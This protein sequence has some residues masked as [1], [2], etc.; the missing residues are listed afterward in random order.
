MGVWESGYGDPKTMGSGVP[1]EG[2][3]LWGQC[4]GV[5]REGWGGL[6]PK[7]MLPSS[8]RRRRNSPSSTSAIQ[9]D[10]PGHQGKN[11]GWQA[12]TQTCSP[13]FPS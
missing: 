6:V 2:S 3:E 10:S 7:M 5:T 12:L 11:A 9:M 4:L 1:G 13:L 8:S